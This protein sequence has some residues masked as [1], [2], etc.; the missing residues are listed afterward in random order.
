MCLAYIESVCV[1]G[2]CV[3]VCVV[4]VWVYVIVK[5]YKRETPSLLLIVEVLC[6]AYTE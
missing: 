6:L 1:R 5:E 2:V 3:L 4:Y